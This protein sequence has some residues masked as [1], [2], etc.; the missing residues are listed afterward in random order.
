MRFGPRWQNTKRTF[1]RPATI[2]WPVSRILG[3]ASSDNSC[4]GCARG[5]LPVSSRE[6]LP[7]VSPRASRSVLLECARSSV[8][9]FTVLPSKAVVQKRSFMVVKYG[10]GWLQL[11]GLGEVRQSSIQLSHLDETQ[12]PCQH[13]RGE[14][15]SAY[16][17][18]ADD[19]PNREERSHKR[20]TAR[21]LC[22]P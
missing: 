14:S 5:S 6:K 4:V 20:A 17:F 9:T 11:A 22:A 8:G 2:R 16:C 3:K 10:A 19:P 12:R 13:Q 15:N 21:C 1:R 7:S 18:L